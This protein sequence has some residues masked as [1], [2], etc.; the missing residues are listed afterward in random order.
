MNI[1]IIRYILGLVLKIEAGLLL[2]PAIVGMFYREDTFS[3]YLIVATLTF[4]VGSIVSMA[5]PKNTVFHLKEGCIATALS[6]ILL[7]L[8]GA[9]PFV[10]T[11]E[12]PS[13]VDAFFETVSGFTTTGA[14][15]LSDVES[16]SHASLFWRSFTHW[17]GGMGVLVFLLAIMPLSGGSNINLMKAESPGPS[18][19]KLVPKVRSSATILYQIYFGM[20]LIQFVLLLIFKMPVF[21]AMC[22]TFG[23][24]GTGGFGVRNDSIASYSVYQQWIIGIF[25]MLFGINFNFYYFFLRK[26]MRKAFAIEEV[27]WYLL[28]IIGATLGIFLQLGGMV[29]GFEHKLRVAFFQV[30]SMITTTG[31]STA[32]FNVWLP[33]AQLILLLLMFSGACAGSTGGGFKVSRIVI[34]LKAFVRE[35]KSYIHPKSVGQIRMDKS[36]LPEGVVKS[37]MVYLA[38]YILIFIVSH[39]LITLDGKDFLTSFSAVTATFNNIGPGLSEVGP[40]SNYASLSAFSKLVLSFDMLAGRLELFPM[41]LLITP[42][43]WKNTHKQSKHDLVSLF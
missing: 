35:I 25:M 42:A 14:S 22:L 17:V 15:I 23:T 41:L 8:V 43:M 24:A 4:I 7:S 5:K 16:I 36:P 6:W 27:R 40:M 13:F 18:V 37:T 34:L 29:S 38:T 39:F 33:N 19:G 32:D 1:N 20:T 10:I 12:I 3:A 21:D 28:F 2:L 9:I 11:K 31:Y 26:K 30:V